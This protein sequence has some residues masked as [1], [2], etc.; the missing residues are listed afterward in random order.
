MT[1]REKEDSAKETSLL[2]RMKTVLPEYL[3]NKIAE[4]S[5]VVIQ[6]RLLAKIEYFDKWIIENKGRVMSSLDT[7]AKPDVAFVLTRIMHHGKPVVNF[8]YLEGIGHLYERFTKTEMAE[9]IKIH[10]SHRNKNGRQI[11]YKNCVFPHYFV[12]NPSFDTIDSA[13]VYGA[14]KAIEEYD[15]RMRGREIFRK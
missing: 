2:T 10:I 9:A 7:W 12:P 5:A 1:R 3:I 8:S 15:K 4:F 11:E 14:Y 13:R 6:Q